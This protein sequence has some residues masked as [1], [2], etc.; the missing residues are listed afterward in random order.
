MRGM[1]DR[2]HRFCPLPLQS[3]QL[4]QPELLLTY[5][6]KDK[7]KGEAAKEGQGPA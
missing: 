2:S 3:K 4:Q 7:K 6:V 5:H 1:R